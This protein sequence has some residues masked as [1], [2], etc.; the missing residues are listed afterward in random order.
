WAD[1]GRPGRGGDA[2]DRV[3]RSP[4][5]LLNTKLKELPKNTTKRDLTVTGPQLNTFHLQKRMSNMPQQ[6]R[7]FKTVIFLIGSETLH[8]LP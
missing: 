6:R 8:S 3:I 4:T 5:P 7:M 2:A 1:R